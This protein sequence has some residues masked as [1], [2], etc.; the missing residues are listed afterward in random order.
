MDVATYAKYATAVITELD[1]LASSYSKANERDRLYVTPAQY[2]SHC[3]VQ[4]EE[5]VLER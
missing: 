1:A 3:V 2:N 5:A 4:Y